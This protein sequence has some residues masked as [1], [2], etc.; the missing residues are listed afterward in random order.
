MENQKPFHIHIGPLFRHKAITDLVTAFEEVLREQNER[1]VMFDMLLNYR[2][3]GHN[4]FFV[5]T[6]KPDRSKCQVCL[7]LVKYWIVFGNFLFWSSEH[8]PEIGQC[9][10]IEQ[11]GSSVCWLLPCRYDVTWLLSWNGLI[12]KS[13]GVFICWHQ[14]GPFWL[15]LI[16][17]T[18]H[19]RRQYS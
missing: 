4:G 18:K 6:F 10:K 3:F 8:G 19:G 11:F 16:S 17:S 7:Q 14:R 13:S 9:L 1:N 12:T 15:V 5:N 2:V